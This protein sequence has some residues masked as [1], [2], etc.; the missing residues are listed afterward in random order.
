MGETQRGRQ[1]LSFMM[2][3]L[4]R[5]E[6]A[7]APRDPCF[8]MFLRGKNGLKLA[9]VQ[10]KLMRLSL[11]NHPPTSLGKLTTCQIQIDILGHPISTVQYF[12]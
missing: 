12:K 6:L 4:A 8:T 10:M 9:T 3:S 11:L 2:V 5:C 7:G 1:A